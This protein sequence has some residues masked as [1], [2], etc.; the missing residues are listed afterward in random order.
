MRIFPR[1]CCGRFFFFF[2]FN[3]GLLLRSHSLRQ[4]A[5]LSKSE[6]SGLSVLMPHGG[7]AP[8]PNQRLF[9]FLSRAHTFPSHSAKLQCLSRSPPHLLSC[10]HFY[11]DRRKNRL[12]FREKS[13]GHYLMRSGSVR[14][15][16]TVIF[17][18]LHLIILIFNLDEVFHLGWK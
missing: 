12:W 14:L 4:F 17:A 3:G 16:F 1:G 13:L 5:R 2:L 6:K 7:C 9:S 8:Y 11:L 15:V 18:G 10:Q